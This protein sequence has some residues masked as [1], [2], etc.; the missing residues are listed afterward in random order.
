VNNY[1]T[2]LADILEKAVEILETDGWVQDAYRTDPDLDTGRRAH[3]AVGAIRQATGFYRWI[4]VAENGEELPSRWV[5]D[6]RDRSLVTDSAI[7]VIEVEDL[8]SYN[9]DVGTKAEDVINLL[10]HAAKDLRNQK[11][12]A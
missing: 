5:D 10:K 9:D 12:V 7:N 8:I 11:E 4:D 6:Q 2:D 1:P 3:C